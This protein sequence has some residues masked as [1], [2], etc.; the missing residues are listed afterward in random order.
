MTLAVDATAKSTLKA[1]VTQIVSA[2]TTRCERK[3]ARALTSLL[4]GQINIF[5]SYVI[6]VGDLR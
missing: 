2:I 6:F 4:K 5:E 3:R 1:S